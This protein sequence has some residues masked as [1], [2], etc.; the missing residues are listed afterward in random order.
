MPGPKLPRVIGEGL[1][2]LQDGARQRQLSL[3]FQD[4]AERMRAAP[5]AM[6]R[7]ALFGVVKPGRRKYVK[8]LPLPMIGEFSLA[9]TGERLDQSDLD[10]YLQ[11]VHYARQRTVDD[12][13]RF[14]MR[15]LLRETGRGT[16]KSDYTWI[17]GRILSMVAC[18]MRISD[19]KGRVLLTGGLIRDFGYD[20][21]T[22]EVK[23]RLN[24]YL[25]GLFEDYTLLNWDDRLALGPKQLAKWLHA[26]YATHA[27]PHPMRVE[28]LMALCGS[29]IA[30]L[31]KFR[32]TLRLALEELQARKLIR[33]WRI[34][35]RD[36]VHVTVEP[37]QSQAR[38]NARK[39]T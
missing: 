39:D 28:M 26:F 2:R 6:L 21:T 10:I 20:E 16:G 37:S 24:P 8:D 27:A 32:Q 18:A 38:H 33:A 4:W 9:Y 3:P 13:L 19:G 5:N 7:S 15:R 17:D 35:T 14:P 23:C 36:L 1:D 11:I 30:D 29:E 34:D 22:G 12:E 31:K 25:R